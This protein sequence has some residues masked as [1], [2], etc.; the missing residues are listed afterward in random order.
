LSSELTAF[1]PER[2]IVGSSQVLRALRRGVRLRVFLARDADP[3]IVDPIAE[4]AL[5]RGLRL[6]WVG[7]KEELGRMFGISRAAAAAALIEG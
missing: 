5:G 3:S 6:E 4:L 1:P 2:R 7:S